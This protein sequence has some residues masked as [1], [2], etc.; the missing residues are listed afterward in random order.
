MTTTVTMTAGA[1]LFPESAPAALWMI[2]SGEVSLAGSASAGPIQARSGDIIGS[3]QTL[4]GQPLGLAGTVVTAGVALR[5]VREELFDVLGERPELLRQMFAA[6]F[7][8]VG[9]SR[10]RLRRLQAQ[11]DAV[12]S[13]ESVVGSRSPSSSS[14]SECPFASLERWSPSSPPS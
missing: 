8:R 11:S 1:P 13:R 10:V 2:L 14:R 5:I 12:G 4:S 9:G 3:L 6:M 7:R